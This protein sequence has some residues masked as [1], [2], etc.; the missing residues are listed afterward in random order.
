MTK[1]QMKKDYCISDADCQRITDAAEKICSDKW[2][3]EAVSAALCEA[4]SWGLKAE[5]GRMDTSDNDKHQ[6]SYIVLSDA[7]KELQE[8]YVALQ[9]DFNDV[10]KSN[11]EQKEILQSERVNTA[12]L[13]KRLEEATRPKF[14]NADEASDECL[15]AILKSRGFRGSL[16]NTMLKTLD[17]GEDV[18]SEAAFYMVFVDGAT[19]PTFQHATLGS[20][21]KEAKRLS[22]KLNR[23]SYIL[24]PVSKVVPVVSTTEAAL[25]ESDK[26]VE[27]PF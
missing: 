23:K 5:A 1:E 19:N 18:K 15:A 2:I 7:Y 8:K 25:D 10:L 22:E 20:A 4:Y 17:I 9:K 6:M 13:Y 16:T 24:V 14:I 3:P 27:L 21:V 12:D 11:Q 26:V